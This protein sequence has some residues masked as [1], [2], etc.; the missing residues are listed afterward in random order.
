MKKTI[1][2]IFALVYLVGF[3]YLAIP[4]KPLPDISDST[5]SHEPGDTVQNPNQKAFFT[6]KD[7][8]TVIGEIKDKSTISIFGF[9]IPP[10]TLN[11]RP[12]ET[13]LFVRKLINSN[14]LEEIVYPL[15]SSVFVNGWEPENAPIFKD[16]SDEKRPYIEIN[17]IRYLAKITLRPV[18]S[19]VISRF[20][21]WSLILPSLF[22]SLLSLKKSFSKDIYQDLKK[23]V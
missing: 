11:Y 12:E 10:L 9:K 21:V 18:T 15:R 23:Y 17:N 3:V 19:S 20:L 8:K 5:R 6:Q 14:Y 1:I 4:I 7:R 16:Y 2:V 22:L 13:A